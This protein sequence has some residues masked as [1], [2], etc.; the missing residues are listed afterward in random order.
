LPLIEV[1]NLHHTYVLGNGQS[2]PALRGVSFT[3]ERGEYVAVVGANGSGKTTLALHLNGILTPNEGSV[4]VDGIDTADTRRSL[5]VK[6]RVGVVFQSPDD[7]LIATVVEEDVAFGPEN[8]GVEHERLNTIVTDA[9]RE[10]GMEAE[11]SRPPHQLS[12]GQKQ[13]I[14]IA[15]VL[16]MSPQCVVLDE[17]TSMLDPSGAHRTIEVVENLNRAGM[18]IVT[19]T[20]K[21]EEAARA[22]RV[23]VLHEGQMVADGTPAAIFTHPGLPTWKLRPPAAARLAERLRTH[24]PALPSVLTPAELAGA[25]EEVARS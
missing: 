6:Q 1:R 7:Q 15:G 22:R 3:V 23:I 5:D 11:R 20:H 14:A 2:V 25:L 19:V 13:R 10:V 9:L 17:V 18:S 21:M 4:I 16:A 12:A 24:F 8:L